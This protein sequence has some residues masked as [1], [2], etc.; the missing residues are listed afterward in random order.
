MKNK[1]RITTCLKLFLLLVLSISYVGVFAQKQTFSEKYYADL[2]QELIGGEQEVPVK[3]GRVDLLTEDYAFEIKKDTNWK[4]AI[5]QSLW[6]GCQTK[7]KPG[8]ILIPDGKDMTYATYL[9]EALR[10]AKLKNTIE[11]YL[12]PRDTIALKELS[13]KRSLKT[14]LNNLFTSQ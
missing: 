4:E 3:G 10:Y 2:I 14:R 6:Y 7:K 9:D 11:V 13:K 8:I 5:G 1:E 12:Y